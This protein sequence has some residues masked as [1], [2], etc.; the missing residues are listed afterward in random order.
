MEDEAVG[1]P[2]SAWAALSTTRPDEYGNQLFEQ[3]APIALS[4]QNLVSLGIM[5]TD[6]ELLE[7]HSHRMTETPSSGFSSLWREQR[8]GVVK[9]AVAALIA[10]LLVGTLIVKKQ[11]SKQLPVGRDVSALSAGGRAGEGRF[12]RRRAR[13]HEML[14]ESDTTSSEELEP[15]ED[16]P[17]PEQLL[18]LEQDTPIDDATIQMYTADMKTAVKELE[19]TWAGASETA[20]KAFRTN[21]MVREE[22]KLPPLT[23]MAYLRPHIAALIRKSHP[24]ATPTQD[25]KHALVTDISLVT[26]IVK[27]ATS[28]LDF[29]T[30]LDN[31][32]DGSGMGSWLLDRDEVPLPPPTALKE[33]NDDLVD[34]EQ[35]A[36]MVER[37]PVIFSK[38]AYADGKDKI[39]RVLAKRLADVVIAD[40]MQLENDRYVH[41][42]FGRFLQ[43]VDLDAP[44]ITDI[45]GTPFLIEPMEKKLTLYAL[46]R[47]QEALTPRVVGSWAAEWNVDDVLERLAMNQEE[48]SIRLKEAREL[49]PAIPPESLFGL[50][51]GLL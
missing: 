23:P 7:R 3:E 49:K 6:A 5:H 47:E 18:P 41:G 40:Q 20:R 25:S 37:M 11:A 51:L 34:F 33:D 15:L 1:S 4:S 38:E 36:W 21:Y 43:S 42:I 50:A 16:V 12:D 10:A 32:C 45:D 29:L 2:A 8:P 13:R 26:T 17:P 9:A 46:L 19:L 39:P 35:F 31:L 24:N 28:R 14:S 22:E 30:E 48:A 27:A 44:P